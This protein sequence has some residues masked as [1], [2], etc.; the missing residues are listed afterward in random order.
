MPSA[1]NFETKAM[2]KSKIRHSSHANLETQQSIANRKIHNTSA[3][4][5]RSLKF[6]PGNFTPV[7]P[8]LSPNLFR[9]KQ[10]ST[11]ITVVNNTASVSDT[12]GSSFN[13]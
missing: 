6:I 8:E 10:L 11:S 9:A 7:K 12:F 4:H 2:K 3:F 1:F 5:Q 13:Q